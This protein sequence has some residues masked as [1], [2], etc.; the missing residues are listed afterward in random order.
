MGE[1]VLVVGSL[2]QDLVVPVPRHPRPGETAIGGDLARHPGGKGANQAVAAARMGAAVRMVG[3]VG[4]DAFG[5]ALIANL[6]REGVDTRGVRALAGV[7]TGVALITVDPRGE[8]AIVV[9]PGANARLGPENLSP[10]EFTGARVVLLQLE[11]PLDAVREAA[12]LGKEAGALVILNAAPA[13]KLPEELL[14]LLDLLVVNEH[15]A[16]A[17]LEAAPPE[18]P[19]EALA[20]ARTLSQRVPVAV[21]TLGER[22]LAYAGREDAG[23]LPAFPVQAVDTT[24][25]GDAFVGALAAAL[26]EGASLPDALRLGAAAG[27]LAATQPGAQPSMPR[28]DEVVALLARG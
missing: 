21:I 10:A 12:R 13:Q 16:A 3:R 2:N 22:G 17:I 23:T 7:P 4:D 1:M 24:A 27:A 5:R 19:E 25:A 26:A 15:E 20:Q 28:R 8:N 6:K 9:S 11:V 14:A 18:T